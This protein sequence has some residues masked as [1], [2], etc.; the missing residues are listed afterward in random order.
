MGHE[1]QLTVQW[2]KAVQGSKALRSA[3]LPSRVLVSSRLLDKYLN[4]RTIVIKQVCFG[5]LVVT[6]SAGF[7][8]GV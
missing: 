3:S 2:G 1:V 8:Q 5:F 7:V 6:P 4:E